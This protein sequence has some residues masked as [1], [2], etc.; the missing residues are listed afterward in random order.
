[1]RKNVFF[2]IATVAV[3]NALGYGII[4]PV[5]YPYAKE[6]GLSDFQNGLLFS[7]FSLCQFFATPVI[8][9]LSDKYGRR[10]LLIVS[11]AG[12]ALSFVLMALAKSGSWLFVARAL[13]GLTAGNISVA[14]AVISDTTKPEDR[15][16]GFGII[17]AAFGFG[18]V[19]GP[20]ISALTLGLGVSA[21]FLIAAAV[22]VLALLLVIFLLPETNVHRGVVSREPLFQFGKLMRAVVDEKVG[23][24]LLISLQYSFALSLLIFAYQPFSVHILKLTARQISMNFTA[25]GTMGLVTQALFL[26]KVVKKFG[27]RKTLSSGLSLAIVT[28]LGFFLVR[29][30]ILFVVVSL[31]HALANGL[32][33]PMVQTLLSREVDARSQGAILGIN[34][35]FVSLGMIVGPIIGGL[36]ATV[37]V[38]LPFLA[39]SIVVFAC[40]LLS[41]QILPKPLAPQRSL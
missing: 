10:P 31:F 7:I 39:G 36:L 34:A 26:P 32:I 15:A 1:M 19:F 14:A 21:P 16:R 37:F 27:D 20:A 2:L 40:L 3:V 8:G 24:T 5:L 4:I 41:I 29:T 25:F 30:E 35:S 9:R 18:F 17:G 11:I 22:S 28:F 33:N 13:D 6:F 23:T 38:P 12:T